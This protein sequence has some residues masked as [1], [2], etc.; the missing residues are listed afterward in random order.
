MLEARFAG[1]DLEAVRSQDA[2]LGRLRVELT[3]QQ[4]LHNE[5]RAALER[6]LRWHAENAVKV[7]ECDATITRQVR[8]ARE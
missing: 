2:T 1:V 4:Q 7:D 5:E 3:R 6:K 8:R